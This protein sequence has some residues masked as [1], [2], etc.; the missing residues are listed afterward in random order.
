MTNWNN[1]DKRIAFLALFRDI[2]GNGPSLL[3]KDDEV[4][5]KDEKERIEFAAKEA[6]ALVER[7]FTKYPDEPGN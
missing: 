1:K 7:L 2:Y 3:T 5:E 4:Y 6:I